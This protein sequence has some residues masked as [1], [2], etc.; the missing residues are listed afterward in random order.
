M[1]YEY[2]AAMTLKE[3][4]LKKKWNLK[5]MADFLG[6]KAHTTVWNYENLHKPK[7]DEMVRI[8]KLTK[9]KVKLKDWA[10]E[11]ES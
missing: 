2:N 6:Y 1:V 10:D 5:Q 9:D 3:F 11:E 7:Y 4:R 8:Q